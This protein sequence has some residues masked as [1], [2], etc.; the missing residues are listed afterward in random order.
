MNKAL[1]AS[2]ITLAVICISVGALCATLLNRQFPPVK[3]SILMK[4]GRLAM[5]NDDPA[6]AAEKFRT[7][8]HLY[9]WRTEPYVLLAEAC[10]ES[11]YPEEAEYFLREALEHNPNRKKIAFAM[12]QLE[13]AIANPKQDESPREQ[14]VPNPG[15]ISYQ[16]KEGE[17][18]ADISM[19]FYETRALASNIFL[20]NRG[21]MENEND[22]SA[23]KQII[24]PHDPRKTAPQPSIEPLPSLEPTSRPVFPQLPDP[25]D[26]AAAFVPTTSPTGNV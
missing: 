16:V 11:G 22:I 13:Y 7:V 18:L 17:T 25:N 3:M 26:P 12:T 23:G 2:L 8:I 20:R 1:R 14:P 4:E 10:T 21:I 19:A 9:P 15:E 6:D 24:I 5:E